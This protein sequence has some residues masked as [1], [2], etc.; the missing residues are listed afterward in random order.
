MLSN[1][2]SKTPT[3]SGGGNQGSS[4]RSAGKCSVKPTHPESDSRTTDTYRCRN[5]LTVLSII[6]DFCW[7]R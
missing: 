1:S 4:R 6:I 2:A 7:S 3:D 5:H